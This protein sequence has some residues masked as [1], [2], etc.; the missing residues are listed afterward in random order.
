M[1]RGPVCFAVGLLCATAARAQAPMNYLEGHGAR[2]AP[3]TP[4][5]WGTMLISIFVVIFICAVLL[6]SLL[7]RRASETAE[8]DTNQARD[9]GH[10]PRLLG[11]WRN[12][13]RAVRR[14]GV[15]D[16]VAGG[17]FEDAGK[18][19]LPSAWTSS[20]ING[21]GSCT[22][23]TGIPRMTSRP[24][25]RSTF[26]SV[27]RSASLCAA[28]TSSIRSGFPSSPARPTSFRDKP[29]RPGCTPTARESIGANVVSSAAS[30]TRTWRFL[31]SPNRKRSSTRGAISSSRTR[32]PRRV[33]RRSKTS[34]R[35]CRNA[36]PVMP[37]VERPRMEFMDQI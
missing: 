35:S 37:C 33:S 23:T 2:A 16:A 10:P 8:R 1:K 36:E 17:A 28:P 27:K 25:M 13:G 5:T 30:S 11:R 18:R 24:R 20:V 21:G 3:V 22:I 4:L 7:R 31:W 12:D 26:P 15:D 32:R 29:T 14:H 9:E 34:R 6:A 19:V